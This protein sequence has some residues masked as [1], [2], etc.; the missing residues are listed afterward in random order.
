VVLFRLGLESQSRGSRKGCTSAM[1]IFGKRTIPD[2]AEVEVKCWISV[3]REYI[4]SC[5]TVICLGITQKKRLHAY[6]SISC[7]CCNADSM[8]AQAALCRPT[9]AQ[10]SQLCARL[11]CVSSF[12][13]G[14]SIKPQISAPHLQSVVWIIHSLLHPLLHSAG[15]WC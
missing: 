4:G 5:K 7:I 6:K 15:K 10:M 14:S 13:N 8:E 2:T 9:R 1:L 3:Q 11:D 12:C